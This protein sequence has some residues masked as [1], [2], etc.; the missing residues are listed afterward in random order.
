M[1]RIVLTVVAMV[2]IV[3]G[4]SAAECDIDNVLSGGLTIGLI[5]HSPTKSLGYYETG[6]LFRDGEDQI[7]GSMKE[8]ERDGS[9]LIVNITGQPC[10][11]LE[12]NLHVSIQDE[13]N[14]EIIYLRKV[15]PT[16]YVVIRDGKNVGT[17]EGSFP[18]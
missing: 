12:H 16:A 5:K 9:N 3:H 8:A 15:G 17:I 13:N 7:V 2:I 10:G 11:V 6:I 1:I 14:K 4:A 18:R